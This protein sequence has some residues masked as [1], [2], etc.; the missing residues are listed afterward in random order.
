M[1]ALAQKLPRVV[2]NGLLA[3]PADKFENIES[4]SSMGPTMD[5]RIKPDL[6]APGSGITSALN[7]KGCGTQS[8]DGTS[9]ATPIVAGT[10]AVLRQYFIEGYYPTGSAVV[11]N[12]QTPSAAMLKATVL[13]G[14]RTMR[15]FVNDFY[16]SS[17]L[18]YL[19]PIEPPPS[20]K[21]GALTSAIILETSSFASLLHS[22]H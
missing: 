1:T 9:M 11:A 5:G 13:N 3:L 8:L 16:S 15:G 22:F 7:T 14:A 12:K 20:C 4:F 10:I 18:A 17:P 6:T 2:I 19:M 21:Q